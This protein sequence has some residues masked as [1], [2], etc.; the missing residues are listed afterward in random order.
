MGSPERRRPRAF[1]ANEQRLDGRRQP[2]RPQRPDPD[3]DRPPDI[4]NILVVDASIRKT[5]TWAVVLAVLG[6]FFFLLGLLFLLV[7]ETVPRSRV[8]IYL[9]SN[10]GT[11]VSV[12]SLYAVDRTQT[13]WYPVF[14]AIERG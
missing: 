12:W 7:K 10:P 4:E 9:K 1:M 13:D 5:P 11:P 6:I 8:T 3:E 14:A 2:L